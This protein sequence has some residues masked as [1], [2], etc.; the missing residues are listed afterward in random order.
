MSLEE[1]FSESAM[2]EALDVLNGAAQKLDEI[3]KKL[4]GR[5]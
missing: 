5:V 3:D 2:K 1:K 4:R